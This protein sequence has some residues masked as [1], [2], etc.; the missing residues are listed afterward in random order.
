MVAI[1]FSDSVIAVRRLAGPDEPEPHVVCRGLQAA[2][3]SIDWSA[4]G[5]AIRASSAS[6][7]LQTCTHQAQQSCVR[8]CVCVCVCVCDWMNP[9]RELLVRHVVFTAVCDA[10]GQG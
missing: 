8:V 3:A 6:F 2:L 5:R 10:D 7:E 9:C 1:G 4:D